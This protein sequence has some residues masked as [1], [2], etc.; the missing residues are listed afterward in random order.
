MVF[1]Q[2]MISLVAIFRM[3]SEQL[4]CFLCAIPQG[5]GGFGTNRH[6]GLPEA[7]CPHAKTSI[8]GSTKLLY[9][10]S[11]CAFWRLS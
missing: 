2:G 7:A 8:L 3:V 1:F 4:C 11:A 6:M 9:A 10:C 5:K